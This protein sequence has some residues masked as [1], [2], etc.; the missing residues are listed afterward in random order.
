MK[1]FTVVDVKTGHYPD[2][3]KI[4]RK[5]EWAKDLMYCSID[6]FAITE[7][8]YLVLMDACGNIAYCPQDRFLVVEEQGK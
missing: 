6:G 8:G 3:G 7:D 2:V 1:P 4:A 5:E